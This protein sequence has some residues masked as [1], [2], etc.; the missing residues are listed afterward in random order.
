MDLTQLPQHQL[1]QELEQKLGNPMDAD[2]LMS[3]KRIMELDESESFQEEFFQ[4]LLSLKLHHQYV[5]KEL[6]GKLESYEQV[7]ELGRVLARRDLSTAVTSS[8]LIWS[9]I[10]WVGGND[11]LKRRCAEVTLSN[12][13]AP[14][15]AYSEETHGSDLLANELTATK[16]DNGYILQGE[17]WPINRAA[18]SDVVM[19]LARTSDDN[20][21]RNL[22][23]FMVE[24]SKLD[25]STFTYLP[26]VKTYGLRGCDICG[27]RFSG[28]EVSQASLIGNEGD[29]LEI[30]IKAF[31]VTRTLCAALSI[32]ALENNLRVVMDF[33]LNR[34]LYK[35]SVFDIPN[36]RHY[37]TGAFVDLL[38]T[39]AV[40]GSLIRA[41]HVIP[42]QLSILSAVAKCFAP[43]KLDKAQKDLATVLGA[44]FFFR[45]KH[46]EG[47]FQKS[48]RDSQV[49]SLFDGS[50]EVNLYSLGTQLPLLAR[51]QN[52]VFSGKIENDENLLA[53][54]FTVTEK[55]EAFDGQKL[56]LSSHSKDLIMESWPLIM[57][58]LEG[59]G[60]ETI[61]QTI[62]VLAKKIFDK[63]QHNLEISL[64]KGEER[65]KQHSPKMFKLA[66][67]YCLVHAAACSINYW[68]YNRTHSEQYIADGEWLA[69]G[70]ERLLLEL[71]IDVSIVADEVYER[72]SEELL[73][74]TQQS[75]TYSLVKLPM[76]YRSEEEKVA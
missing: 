76:T 14:C 53:K 61:E 22:S 37:L 43:Y 70:L 34:Q 48:M 67:Q 5:P 27:I 36:A 68:L 47:I 8:T 38:L 3:F 55:V 49:V 73:R 71:N 29:G 2:T 21:A 24:K 6:G 10:A 64:G 18:R 9:I 23:L 44:R 31:Q 28:T 75:E 35:G 58:K 4:F 59:S 15:L 33:A 56:D 7:Y 62:S 1:A 13:C 63:H 16:T 12:N 39:D 17:K 41:A 11:V 54:L 19:L 51:R 20:G 65:L 30:A 69:V 52:K 46:C 32:G 50:S 40:G 74:R 42:Q 25:P 66:K 72:A 45:E 57:Q 60:S 26:K